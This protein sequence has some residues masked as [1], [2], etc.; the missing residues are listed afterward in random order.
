MLLKKAETLP[1]PDSNLT[2]EPLGDGWQKVVRESQAAASGIP[3][4]RLQG[5]QLT[6]CW[7]HPH[8]IPCHHEWADARAIKTRRWSKRVSL[9][10]QG[11]AHLLV[12]RCAPSTRVVRRC[13][14]ALTRLTDESSWAGLCECIALRRPNTPGL[15]TSGCGHSC[16]IDVR[17]RA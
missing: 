2:V 9:A 16:W 14:D 13:Y 3:T 15:W 4:S 10:A 17:I 7:R 5:R 6:L 1:P 11:E 8:S 12:T